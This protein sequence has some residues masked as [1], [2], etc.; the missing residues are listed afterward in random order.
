MVARIRGASSPSS[1]FRESRVLHH[2]GRRVASFE[3]KNGV[4]TLM[5]SGIKDKSWL[6]LDGKPYIC[7]LAEHLAE[8]ENEGITEVLLKGAGG[9]TWR[10]SLEEFLDKGRLYEHPQRGVQVAC[11]QQ[12]FD[13]K[14]PQQMRLL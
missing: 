12:W 8:A 5:R 4:G 3:W 10:I 14:D 9:E 2:F 6:Y 1:R 11:L 7:F 13:H